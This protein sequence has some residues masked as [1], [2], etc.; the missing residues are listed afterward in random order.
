MPKM[1]FFIL[2]LILINREIVPFL[3][4]NFNQ[5]RIVWGINSSLK[6]VLQIETELK[7]L[8]KLKHQI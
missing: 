4:H 5:N 1:A 2:E 8:Q 7:K 6:M 3:L